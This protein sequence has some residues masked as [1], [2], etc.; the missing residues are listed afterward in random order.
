MELEQQQQQQHLIVN[1]VDESGNKKMIEGDYY[2]ILPSEQNAVYPPCGIIG[3]LKDT[4]FF[5]L[6]C[7]QYLIHNPMQSIIVGLTHP[8]CVAI[9][10]TITTGYFSGVVICFSQ[11]N[12]R[13][14][15]RFHPDIKYQQF[16]L[17]DIG[18]TLMPF[19]D[20]VQFADIYLGAIIIICLVFRFFI[21]KYR[22]IILRRYFTLMGVLFAI[23][24]VC[25]YLT[26]L[27]DPS[28]VETTVNSNPF[29]EGFYIM[30][31][32]HFS[33][34]DKLF[35]GHTMSITLIALFWSHYS[36]R[37]PII[38]F[39]PFNWKWV[40]S[41]G[42]PLKITLTSLYVWVYVMIGWCLF[43]MLRRHY[44][45]D[46]FL[47]VI[48]CVVVFEWYHSYILTSCTR[49]NTLNA[50]IMWMEQDAPD[51]PHEMYYFKQE[52]P[53]ESLQIN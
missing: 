46:V 51:I 8:L 42:Y 6:T 40:T 12:Q 3:G 31:G 37:V 18:F 23:R 2:L 32:L 14:F 5:I 15:Y 19:V 27:P 48:I 39:N 25:V 38:D 52:I 43:V 33:T 4:L 53:L 41:Y 45:V 24:L 17:D 50:F 28:R 22:L 34:V 16:I 21:T 44:S 13:I 30:T 20:I 26:I 47:G 10:L 7:L 35:S 49:K 11:E 9:L 29:L 1:G 36:G